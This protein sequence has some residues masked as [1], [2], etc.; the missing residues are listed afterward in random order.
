MTFRGESFLPVKLAGQEAVQRP[1][2]EAPEQEWFAFVFLRDNPS[3]WHDELWLH[4]AGCRSWFK[5]RRNT[6]THEIAT[7]LGLHEPAP[8]PGPER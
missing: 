3:G 7:S 1:H 8:T 2:S 4:S 6:R 5:L